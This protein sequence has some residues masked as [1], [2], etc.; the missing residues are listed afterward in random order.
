MTINAAALWYEDPADCTCNE[1]QAETC[2]CSNDGWAYR[3]YRGALPGSGRLFITDAYTGLFVDNLDIPPM[4]PPPQIM[5]DGYLAHFA[6]ILVLSPALHR[7]PQGLFPG[8]TL[9][10]LE[11]AGYRVRGLHGL[12][13]LASRVG[14]YDW[15]HAIIDPDDT[16]VGLVSEV[17]NRHPGPHYARIPQQ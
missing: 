10:L 2:L 16:V 3:M 5:S 13:A 17:K 4:M 11:D 7:V 12:P 15:I 1:D 14:D 8:V 9:D 6:K